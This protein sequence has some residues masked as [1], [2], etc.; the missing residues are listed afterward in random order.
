VCPFHALT[1]AVWPVVMVPYFVTSDGATWH[2]LPQYIGLK[3]G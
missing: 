2:H 3:G 1:F